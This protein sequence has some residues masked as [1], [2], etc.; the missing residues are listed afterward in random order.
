LKGL[1]FPAFLPSD[2]GL[3]HPPAFPSALPRYHR[4]S[5]PHTPVIPESK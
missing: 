1:L 4:I 5:W 3:Y 2:Q